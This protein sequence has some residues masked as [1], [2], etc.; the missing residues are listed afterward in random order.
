MGRYHARLEQRPRSERPAV[1]CEARLGWLVDR[2]S[3][4]RADRRLQTRLPQAKLRHTVCLDASDYRPPRGLDQALGRGLAPGQ[5]GRARHHGLS[6]GPTGL[7]TTWLA[8]A[9]GPQACREGWTVRSL[10]LPRLL[11]ALPLAT[12]DGRS[13]QR[14]TALANTAGRRRDDWSLAPRSAD[15][16]RDF[17]ALRDERHAC[18]ATLVTSQRPVAHWPE[19]MGEPP[20]AE[21]L[22]DRLVH[23]AYHLALQGDSRRTRQATGPQH[24]PA[25]EGR[26]GQRRVAPQRPTRC[27]AAR[28]S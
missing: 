13:G 4:A 19:A 27:G 23:H 20:L 21:A 1:P 2:E 18:R 25:V 16:R 28:L 7:G 5:W 8:G 3:T 10:R 6:T 26:H 11:Q 17:W 24:A 9:L 15:K 12:G 14:R 22:L